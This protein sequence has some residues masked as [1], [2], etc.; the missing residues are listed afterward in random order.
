MAACQDLAPGAAGTGAWAQQ[1]RR[2]AKPIVIAW[3][4][5]S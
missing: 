1:H 3:T 5:A 2:T 4:D